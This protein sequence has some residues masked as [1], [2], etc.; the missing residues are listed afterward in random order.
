[1]IMQSANLY[2]MVETD[3]AYGKVSSKQL[4]KSI[5]CFLSFGTGSLYA[6]N[7]M[8]SEST[9][10]TAQTQDAGIQAGMWLKVADTD[11]L[12]NA[13]NPTGRFTILYL[14]QQGGVADAN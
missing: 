7:Q 14:Q 9:T 11:Y 8:I 10:H 3:T 6:Q 13:V 5:Q 2:G 1:M 12:I 4:I